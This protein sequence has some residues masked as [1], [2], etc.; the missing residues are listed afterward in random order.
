[1]KKQITILIV[2]TLLVILLA[3]CKGG[4]PDP[5]SLTPAPPSYR[6]VA[7]G[8]FVP[9][10]NQTLF[11][12]VRGKVNEVLVKQGEKVSKGQLLVKV[13]D[14]EPAQ[15]SLTAAKLELTSAQ[16]LMDTLLRTANLAKAQAFTSYLG[17]QKN[18][19]DAKLVWDQLDLTAIQT[20]IDDAQKTVDSRKVD[21]EK[22]QTDFNKY[23]DLASDDPNRKTY[24]DKLRTA[25]KNY[26]DALR[27]LLV[28]TNRREIPQTAL[29]VALGL[30]TEAKRAYENT[31]NGPDSDKLALA[32]ARLNNALAQVAAAQYA[33][34]NYELKA[35]FDGVI[36]DLNVSVN[37]LVGPETFAVV[38]I[39]ENQWYVE[40]NDLTEYDVVK[41]KVG[42]SAKITIDA[43]P[44]IIMSGIVEDIA[45]APKNLAGDVLYTVRLKVEQP[46]PLLRWGMTMEITFP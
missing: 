11:F 6:V 2:V 5:T 46:D 45:I 33:V 29:D 15:A 10:D 30:E 3:G 21:L 9:R 31:L 42:D 36:A 24:E 37:Q 18:T 41:I 38:L 19:L 1:M 27:L 28:Q 20:G 43:L 26:D 34:D 44:D 22:A 14:D 40:T 8:H 7:G 25:Q 32:Q 17:A 23:K 12:L 13:G 35:P 39:D 4:T 16:Q